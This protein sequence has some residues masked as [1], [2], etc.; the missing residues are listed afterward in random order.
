[1]SNP[2]ILAFR[3]GKLVLPDCPV[4]DALVIARNGVLEYSGA[5]KASLPKDAIVV[6]A[7]GG[8]IAPGFVDIHV[9]GGEGA[10]SMDGSLE[11]GKRAD[12]RLLNKK[13]HP[14]RVFIGGVE[15]T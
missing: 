7:R 15:L 14:K 6:D 8:M 9:H 12:I 2:S 13:L 10:D 11:P 1:M 3:N 4:D 5:A